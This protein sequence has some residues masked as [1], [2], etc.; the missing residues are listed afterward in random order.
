MAQKLDF[1]TKKQTVKW[2]IR[3]CTRCNQL[4]KHTF[5]NDLAFKYGGSFC[6]VC[7]KNNRRNHL[8]N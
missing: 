7:G 6:N 3:F 4:Q 8:T 2:E 1:R 5:Q